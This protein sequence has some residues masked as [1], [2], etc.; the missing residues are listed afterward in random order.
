[1][2]KGPLIRRVCAIMSEYLIIRCLVAS[3]MVRV[4]ILIVA[5][6]ECT[7]A[8]STCSTI[9]PMKTFF[10][11]QTPSTSTSRAPLWNFD[12]TTG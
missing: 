7:P 2:L 12:I 8:F 1:M 11:S 6:P 5:S 9:A 10:P 4:G 3:P